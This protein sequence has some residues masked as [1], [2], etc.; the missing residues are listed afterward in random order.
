MFEHYLN[1]LMSHDCRMDLGPMRQMCGLLGDPQLKYPV[2]HVAGTNGKG[3]T[4][5]FL[6]SLL[7]A[8]GLKVGL[9]TSPHL[10]TL[11]ERIQIDR[12]LI[13]ESALERGVDAVRKMLPTPGYLS[14]FE[15]MALVGFWYFAEQKVDVAIVEVGMGGRLDATNVVQPEVAVITPISFDHQQFLGNTL[16]EIAQEKCGILKPGAKGHRSKV[17]AAPQFAEAMEVIERQCQDLGLSLYKV[18]KPTLVPLG[19][20]GSHQK[21][22]A[23]VALKAAELFLSSTPPVGVRHLEGGWGEEALAKT[24]WPGRIEIVS[25]NPLVLIDG[26]HNPAGAFVLSQYLSEAYKDFEITMLFGAM[27]DKDWRSMM[28]I[29]APL[30]RKFILIK[31]SGDRALGLEPMAEFAT[32]MEWSYETF[33]GYSV[34]F[35]QKSQLWVAT[36]SLYMIGEVRD[37]FYGISNH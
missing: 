25:Q 22:N 6:E 27:Q 28:T 37:Y 15:M 10:Q 34:T 17:V 5:A 32:K 24:E 31:S 12:E 3:S 13:S 1:S 21:I 8:K 19:L 20:K 16:K 14:F 4:C 29:M 2:I 36:G 7:R 9:I 26:A 23:A 35:A 18:E 30:V 33:K 11:R